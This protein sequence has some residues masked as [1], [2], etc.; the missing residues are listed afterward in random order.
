MAWH[1]ALLLGAATVLSLCDTSAAH[2]AHATLA[3]SPTLYKMH[4]TLLSS[5]PAKRS[6]LTQ[7]PKR[8]YLVFSEEIEPTLG[9]IKLVGPDGRV[10]SLT[11]GGDPRNVSALVA[12]VNVALAPGSYRVEWRIVSEDGHP[13]DGSFRFS[14]AP[15]GDTA[16]AS[17]STPAAPSPLAPRAE[18][19][20]ADTATSSGNAL[21]K[22]P[23]PAAA[24]RGLGIGAL[25]AFAGLLAFLLTRRDPAPNARAE[26]LVS[27]LAIAAAALLTLHLVAWALSVSPDHSLGSDQIAALLSSNVGRVELARAGLAVLACWALVLARRERLALAL[28]F[29]AMLVSAD[30]GHSAAIQPLWAIPARALHLF[31]LAAWLGGLLW[32]I[33]CART[34]A[35]VV[36]AEAQRVSSLALTGVIVMAFSGV[37][38]T[39]LF[40]PSWIDLIRSAYGVITL[41]KVAGLCV[42]VL[43]GAHHRY[44]VM[45]RLAESDASDGFASSLGRE[46]A[47][48]TIVILL[49]G[50]L[51]YVPPPTH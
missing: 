38:Q 5:E 12:P 25:A 8:I 28:A 30:T 26:R 34:N 39:R 14:I 10:I 11:A 3:V 4:A 42:L 51:A 47:V 43:F 29:A 15:S 6:T 21:A 37:V 2:A 20:P 22:V 23:V 40:L 41:A 31:A 18:E 46:V 50:L 48:M 19:S 35:S 16:R 9:G 36:A 33:V 24:L 49:G 44:R 13:I 17:A 1:R 27:R 7:P 32:L 45:P